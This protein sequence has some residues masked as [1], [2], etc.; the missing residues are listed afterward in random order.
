M[1]VLGS[2]EREL[3]EMEVETEVEVEPEMRRSHHM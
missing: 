3:V 1:V 2:V